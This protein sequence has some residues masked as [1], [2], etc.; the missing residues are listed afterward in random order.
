MSISVLISNYIYKSNLFE[1]ITVGIVIPEDEIQAKSIA[2]LI[3]T[4][5]SVNKTV[6]LSICLN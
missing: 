4:I 6:N 5:D 1:P 2:R 3:S